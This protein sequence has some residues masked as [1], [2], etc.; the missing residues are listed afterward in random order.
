MHDYGWLV[1]PYQR[2]ELMFLLGAGL[3]EED[4]RVEGDTQYQYTSHP[5]P[6]YPTISHHW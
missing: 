4:V 3:G 6:T 1:M 5:V 2:E